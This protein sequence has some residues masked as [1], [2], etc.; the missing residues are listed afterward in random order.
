MVT[1]YIYIYIIIQGIHLCGLTMQCWYQYTT[2]DGA[3]YSW[4]SPPAEYCNFC[5]QK[6]W[7]QLQINICTCMTWPRHSHIVSWGLIH[8]KR[9][10][11]ICNYGT[12]RHHNIIGAPPSRAAKHGNLLHMALSGT[13]AKWWYYCKGSMIIN[14]TLMALTGTIYNEATPARATPWMA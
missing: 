8:G 1:I 9:N 3:G 11:N 14:G 5:P 12:W 10:K 4:I 7:S 2:I 6:L 13:I